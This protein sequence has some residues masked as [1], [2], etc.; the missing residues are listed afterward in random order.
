MRLKMAACCNH[1]SITLAAPHQARVQGK[2]PTSGRCRACSRGRGLAGTSPAEGRAAAHSPWG[3]QRGRPA[4]HARTACCTAPPAAWRGL[5]ARCAG[6]R[7][8]AM[9]HGQLQPR[10]CCACRHACE[11]A[12][13]RKGGCAASLSAA[14][15]GPQASVGC[16]VEGTS[17]LAWLCSVCWHRVTHLELKHAKLIGR[18]L[19]R[20]QLASAVGQRV[21]CRVEASGGCRRKGCAIGPAKQVLRG[22]SRAA[23]S[24]CGMHQS[25]RGRTGSCQTAA[26]HE[27][28]AGGACSP[29]PSLRPAGSRV[30]LGATQAFAQPERPQTGP[31]SLDGAQELAPALR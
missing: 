13:P 8:L 22:S 17:R 20:I 21:V 31:G 11:Q 6:N 19:W 1:I 27:Q 9:R 10:H 14:R 23:W 26:R 30:P 29:P 15:P 16:L 4:N 2:L 28:L 7:L 18:V 3:A 5:R 25:R 12:S 24:E